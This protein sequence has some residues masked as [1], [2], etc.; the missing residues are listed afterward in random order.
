[1]TL[2]EPAFTRMR[3]VSALA[4]VRCLMSKYFTRWGGGS[5]EETREGEKKTIILLEKKS[6]REPMAYLVCIHTTKM[7][8]VENEGPK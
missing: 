6:W 5:K 1:M 7:Y 2:S 4:V 8:K 3:P